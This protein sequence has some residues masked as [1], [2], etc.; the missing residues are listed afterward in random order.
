M[1]DFITKTNIS[2]EKRLYIGARFISDL[3]NPLIIP[4]LI[5]GLLGYSLFLPLYRLSILILTS[6]I[7]FTLI[8]FSIALI[9]SR[10]QPKPSLDFPERT[11]RTLLY[12]SALVSTFFGG[13]I[14]FGIVDN[15]AIHLLVI[16]FVANLLLSFLVNFKWKISLHTTALTTGVICLLLPGYLNP[17]GAWTLTATALGL[18]IILPLLIWA[19]YYL[20]V[21]SFPELLAG[22]IVGTLIPMAVFLIAGF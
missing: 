1:I 21:H 12:S 11:T 14:L 10:R 5:F 6:F 15:P 13:I 4:P 2:D 16:I 17:P 22:I 7:F 20:R 3:F 8:P 18:G 19:R 9:L